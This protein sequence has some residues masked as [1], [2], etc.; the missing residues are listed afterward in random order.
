MITQYLSI[1]GPFHATEQASLKQY[2]FI[3]QILRAY[4]VRGARNIMDYLASKANHLAGRVMSQAIIIQ[5]DK[6]Y[7][8]VVGRKKSELN[9]VTYHSRKT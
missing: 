3:Q 1:P 9:A 5:Y 6:D 4:S 8:G 7:N 2:S